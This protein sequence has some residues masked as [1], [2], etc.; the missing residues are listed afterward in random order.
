M[1]RPRGFITGGYSR[2]RGNLSPGK[3]VKIGKKR[4]KARTN[5]NPLKDD[6]LHPRKNT[7]TSTTF[8][9]TLDNCKNNRGKGLKTEDTFIAHIKNI[10]SDITHD[11]NHKQHDKLNKLVFKLTKKIICKG[12]LNE[13]SKVN[14]T[15][16]YDNGD[17]AGLCPSCVAMRG[18]SVVRMSVNVAYIQKLKDEMREFDLTYIN[19]MK[20]I[21]KRLRNGWGKIYRKLSYMKRD[22]KTQEQEFEAKWLA[23]IMKIRIQKPMK[24]GIIPFVINILCSKEL[25]PRD[26]IY[27]FGTFLCFLDTVND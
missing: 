22:A 26:I 23:H 3:N 12:C 11:K 5:D 19:V 4:R 1:Y 13:D 2:K 24:A 15:R 9:C 7:K 17:W 8:M 25:A 20:N 10:H 18:K 6:L 21:D 16:C 14:I 27:P